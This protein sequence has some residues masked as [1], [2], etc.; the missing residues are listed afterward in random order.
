MQTSQLGGHP[1]QQSQQQLPPPDIPPLTMAASLS[2]LNPRDPHDQNTYHIDHNAVFG[3]PLTDPTTH[4]YGDSVQQRPPSSHDV[5]PS[6]AHHPH[7]M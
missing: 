3:P 7:T 6:F 2:N 5:L 1:Q 4:P